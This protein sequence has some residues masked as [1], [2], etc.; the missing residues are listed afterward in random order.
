MITSKST[1]H[2]C[3]ECDRVTLHAICPD[4]S[5]CG[6]VNTEP[7]TDPT[8]DQARQLEEEKER[9]TGHIRRFWEQ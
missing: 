7:L 2:I 3:R 8:P 1:P 4:C 5:R 9:L 6:I